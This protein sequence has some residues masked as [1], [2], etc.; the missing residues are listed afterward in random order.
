VTKSKVLIGLDV[1]DACQQLMKPRNLHNINS[2]D[3]QLA[4]EGGQYKQTVITQACKQPHSP[5]WPAAN[6]VFPAQM[7]QQGVRL[8]QDTSR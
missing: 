6:T 8:L 5:R 2:I 3:V 4:V 7:L 1:Q